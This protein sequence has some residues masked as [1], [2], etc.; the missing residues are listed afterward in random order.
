ML[1]QKDWL[2]GNCQT[3]KSSPLA[4]IARQCPENLAYVR[5]SELDNKR[6]NREIRGLRMASGRIVPCGLKNR[7]NLAG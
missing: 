2:T 7:K 3:L 5:I 1:S 6:G 4:G